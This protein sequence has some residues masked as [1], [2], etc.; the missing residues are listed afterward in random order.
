M[1]NWDVVRKELL[2]KEGI[3]A[4][5]DLTQRRVISVCAENCLQNAKKLASA[6]KASVEKKISCLAKIS[7]GKKITSYIKNAE[8]ICAFVVTIG[9]KL[10]GEASRLMKENEQ[11]S[12]YLLDRIG[13]FAVENL[14][15]NFESALRKKYAARKRSVSGRFS[16]GYCDWPTSAQAKLSKFIG[17]GKAGVKLTKSCMMVP[18]KSISSIVA[19]GPEGLF[20]KRKSQCSVCDLKNCNYRRVKR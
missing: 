1:I 10:E 14:A 11:L 5:K 9:D 12:G 19:I 6:K 7:A 3:N 4:V 20:S 13:S 15:E 2:E 18:K 17:F 16:P 8:N